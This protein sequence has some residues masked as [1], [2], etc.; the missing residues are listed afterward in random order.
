[1]AVQRDTEAPARSGRLAPGNSE[2]P[3]GN[4]R[5][6]PGR[7]WSPS[8]DGPARRGGALLCLGVDMAV[9]RDTEAPARSG[10]LAPGNSE[11]PA[12]NFRSEPGRGWRPS[13]DGPARRGGALLCL[14]GR[15]LMRGAAR[16]PGGLLSCPCL[17]G[18]LECFPWRSECFCGSSGLG[19]GLPAVLTRGR[20]ERNGVRGR[21]PRRRAD[22][23]RHSAGDSGLIVVIPSAHD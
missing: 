6:E 2:V 9:Q 10:R 1:M 19:P 15:T 8:P 13:P 18:W 5:S 4:F 16:A 22:L 17:P 14:G 20:S 7:G 12:G 21:G 3:A 23:D 11:V